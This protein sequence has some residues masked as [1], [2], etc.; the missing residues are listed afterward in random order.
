M[1][2]TLIYLLFFLSLTAFSSLDAQPISMDSLNQL[3]FDAKI[4]LAEKMVHDEP[5]F[6]YRAAE[7]A[8]LQAE[9]EGNKKRMGRALPYMS[10]ASFYQNYKID[11]L[12]HCQDAAEYN[13]GAKDTLGLIITRK[14]QGL[15]SQGIEDY[16]RAKGFFENGLTLAQAIG[17]LYYEREMMGL[18]LSVESMLGNR[19]VT[20]ELANSLQKLHTQDLNVTVVKALPNRL[21]AKSFL[22]IGNALLRINEENN[23]ET[24]LK[25]SLQVAEEYNLAKGIYDSQQS[26]GKTFA[27]KGSYGMALVYLAKAQEYERLAND[28]TALA[29]NL[30]LMGEYSFRQQAKNNYEDTNLNN[31]AIG[32]IREALQI[33]WAKNLKYTLRDGYELLAEVYKELKDY[34]KAQSA[35]EKQWEITLL[36]NSETQNGLI[37]ELESKTKIDEMKLKIA[38]AE[39][40]QR[41]MEK[42]K[43]FQLMIFI[44][45]CIILVM[46]ISGVSLVVMG[47]NK[48]SKI[49]LAHNKE[50]ERKNAQLEALNQTKDKFF[51]II[52]HDVKGPL[53][54]LRSFSN[55]LMNHPEHLS[56]DEIKMLAKDLD[57]SL[58]N[59]LGLLENLLIWARSQTGAIQITPEVFSIQELVDK[60]HRLLGNTATNKNIQ[61]KKGPT[62]S[63]SV[64]ADIKCI[65]TVLRNLISNALKFTKKEGEIYTTITERD[66]DVVIAVRDNGVGIP[67]SVQSKL[68]ILGEKHSTMGTGNEKGTGLG[69]ILCKEFVEQNKGKIWFESVEDQGTTFSFTLPK[70]KVSEL[71]TQP[72]QLPEQVA[73]K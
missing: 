19:E 67:K 63:V 39:K 49:L 40:D 35:L 42:E 32:K 14:T 52:S 12:K 60:N 47:K 28:S 18:L 7:S 2:S 51:S 73:H 66:H 64:F 31:Q 38:K 5:N 72:A 44:G 15:I 25:K 17:D 20:L 55:I 57:G 36:I 30:L 16:S 22:E 65:D 43:N 45:I 8:W 58:E 4:N 48:H 26:L 53:H 46:I 56:I 1:K 62:A 68:F 27:K 13:L 23:A 54:S 61:L 37:A 9:S 70:A 3:S 41:V 24:Y 50:I 11:E 59:L 71:P 34:P 6:A 69:L 10:L 29:A 21:V 33:G